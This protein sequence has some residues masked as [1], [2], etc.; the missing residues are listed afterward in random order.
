MSQFCSKIKTATFTNEDTAKDFDISL[1]DVV[2][3]KMEG[4]PIETVVI[5]YIFTKNGRVVV[6]CDQ[7]EA[8]DPGDIISING[9]SIL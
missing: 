9:E 2:K 3:I 7:F 4:E 6:N 5:D 1:N 8:L